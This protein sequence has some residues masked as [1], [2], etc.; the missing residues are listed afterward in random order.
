MTSVHSRPYRLF[1]GQL[2]IAR[3]SAG[4]TQA[5]VAHRLKRYQSYVSKCESGERRV[6]IVDLVEFADLY[7]RPLGYFV[8][9]SRDP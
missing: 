4:L 6:D 9:K 1:L 3:V 7:G 2:K 5:D 8:K